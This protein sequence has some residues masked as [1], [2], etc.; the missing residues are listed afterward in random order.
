MASRGWARRGLAITARLGIAASAAVRLARESRRSVLLEHADVE[1][2]HDAAGTVYSVASR[3]HEAASP[4]PLRFAEAG[5]R[6]SVA[7]S[8]DGAASQ[9]V[10]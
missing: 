7:G 2:E 3:E 6:L 5:G 4:S 9:E 8:V 10:A 1:A